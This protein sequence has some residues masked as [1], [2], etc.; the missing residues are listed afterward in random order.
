MD[1]S[2]LKVAELKDEL[3]KRGLSIKGLKAEL[4]ERLEE[5]LKVGGVEG[6]VAAE[7]VAVVDDKA[8]NETPST[9]S[10][11]KRRGRSSSI[12][13]PAKILKTET[14]V[15]VETITD[16]VE[17]E[18]SDIENTV[19]DAEDNITPEHV[20]TEAIQH[21][22]T[23]VI[24]PAIT[25]VIQPIV[26]EA[27]S[28]VISEV[29]KPV[30]SE[31][32]MPVPSPAVIKPTV[33]EA[34]KAPVTIT[35]QPEAVR[36]NDRIVHVTHLTRPFALSEFKSLF[37]SFG[38]I[39]DLWLDSLKSQSFVTF[40]SAESAQ[41]C[42]LELNGK[43]FPEQTG[44]LLVVEVIS[45]DKMERVKKDLEGLSATAIGATLLNTFSN[46]PDSQSVPLDDLFKK[47]TAEP[48]IYYLPKQQ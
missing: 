34:I 16:N 37:E 4:L 15:A 7:P 19:N 26:S 48:S 13:T 6:T 21:T 17:V 5:A 42:K 22:V 18:V 20:V 33:T 8:V 24:K 9:E 10:P 44:K 23:E 43:R 45:N 3:G 25:E 30:T 39:E 2:K 29:I 40:G 41:R 12:D 46:S 27:I 32:I 11:T 47:T 1:P 28:S 31:E 35:T 36:S 38:S 14:V